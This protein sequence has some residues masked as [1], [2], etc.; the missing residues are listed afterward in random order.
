MHIYKL[1]E[2]IYENYLLHVRGG[3]EGNTIEALL[4][5][6]LLSNQL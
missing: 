1:W 3:N 5:N 2:D 4:S 6:T